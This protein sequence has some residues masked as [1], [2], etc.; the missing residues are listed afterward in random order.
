MVFVVVFRGFL[1][2]SCWLLT[3]CYRR[4]L[5]TQHPEEDQEFLLMRVILGHQRAGLKVKVGHLET[6]VVYLWSDLDCEIQRLRL[7]W[8]LLTFSCP[9]IKQ[10]LELIR[11]VSVLICGVFFLVQF[12]VTYVLRFFRDFSRVCRVDESL[13]FPFS[14]SNKITDFH[15][16]FSFHFVFEKFSLDLNV[17][18]VL[19]FGYWLGCCR[20]LYA[21][22]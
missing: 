19:F 2:S 9:N 15:F 6:V 4:F 12:R 21:K 13:A 16:D 11:F 5:G 17:L 7:G 20:L 22:W 14:F 10:F 3:I 18:P 1:Y 8:L